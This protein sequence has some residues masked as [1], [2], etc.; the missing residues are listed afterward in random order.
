ML[1]VGT[2]TLRDLPAIVIDARD[3]HGDGLLPLHAFASVTFLGTE[4]ALLIHP[5]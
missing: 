5:R 3:P 2:L 4:H 1:Q